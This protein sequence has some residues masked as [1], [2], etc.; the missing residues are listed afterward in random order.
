MGSKFLVRLRPPT[1]KMAKCR[2]YSRT[3]CEAR[4]IS[5]QNHDEYQ[6]LTN[7]ELLHALQLASLSVAGDDF[8]QTV[9]SPLMAE[10]RKSSSPLIAEPSGKNIQQLWIALGH[11]SCY[12]HGR[13]FPL[14]RLI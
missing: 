6:P 2:G 4:Q 7:I 1:K 12:Y 10:L 5:K 8:C 11:E 9:S 13:I 3:R 14:P